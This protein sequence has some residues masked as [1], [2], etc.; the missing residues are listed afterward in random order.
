MSEDTSDE[1]EE[2]DHGDTGDDTD[3]DNSDTDGEDEQEEGEHEAEPSSSVAGLV[4]VLKSGEEVK[5][6]GMDMSRP[7]HIKVGFAGGLGSSSVR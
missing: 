7:L 1:E 4:W 5:L 2:S 3:E 6:E